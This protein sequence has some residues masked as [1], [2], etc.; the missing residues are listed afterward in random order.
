MARQIEF[1]LQ[2]DTNEQ[3]VRRASGQFSR[4]RSLF[5]K[6]FKL[7]GFKRIKRFTSSPNRLFTPPRRTC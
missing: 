4:I 3:R 1:A 5:D 2:C 7:S 6:R